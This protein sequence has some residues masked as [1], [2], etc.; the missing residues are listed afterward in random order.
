MNDKSWMNIT[1]LVASL[2]GVGIAGIVFGHLGL[3]AAKR[4]EAQQRNL[5]LA[6]LIIGYVQ[7]GIIA[8]VV[9][10]Y[11]VFFLVAMGVIGSFAFGSTP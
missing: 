4:G 3:A 8:A 9:V 1:A 2:C 7:V 10:F 6:G 11:F 5:G